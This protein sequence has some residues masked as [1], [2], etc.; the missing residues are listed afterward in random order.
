MVAWQKH[1][2]TPSCWHAAMRISFLAGMA[3][4]DE[5][6]SIDIFE[7]LCDI[8]RRQG[9]LQDAPAG[10]LQHAQQQL[11]DLAELMCSYG[12]PMPGWGEEEDAEELTGATDMAVDQVSLSGA[13]RFSVCTLKCPLH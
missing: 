2:E 10:L 13:S 1:C 12:F 4:G 6:Q 11:A 5:A 3:V 7:E 9:L 8:C